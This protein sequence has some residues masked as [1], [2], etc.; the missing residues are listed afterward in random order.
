MTTPQRYQFRNAPAQ[1]GPLQQVLDPITRRELAAVG[2]KPGQRVMDVGAG[3]GSIVAHLAD[4]VGP[5]GSVT[6]VDLDT[7]LLNPTSVVDV[8]QRDLRTEPLPAEPG[9][10]DLVTARCLLEHLPNRE[11][12][13]RQMIRLLRPG[14]W[15]VL[16]EIVY[17]RVVVRRAPTETDVDLI[18]TVVHAVLDTLAARGVDLHWGDK[19]PGVL[20]AAGIKYVRGR[21][22]TE[23]WTGGG[24]GCALYADNARQLRD[25][26]RDAGITPAQL[27]RFAELMVDP[28]VVVGSYQFACTRAQTQQ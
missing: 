1:L 12:L 21:S 20:L 19:T 6:A 24:P 3:A 10:L 25:P 14:G 23:T 8:Y 15:L 2:V 7:S 17:S 11:G 9:S 4:L 18:T 22:H 16:G 26:L 13:I 27:D 5:T 28:T